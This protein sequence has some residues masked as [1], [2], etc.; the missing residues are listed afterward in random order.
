MRQH[1]KK[2]KL[3]GNGMKVKINVKKF[4]RRQDCIAQI[5]Y[6]YPETI[7]DVRGLIKE[8]V[9]AS[10]A[11]YLDRAAQSGLLHILSA[12]TTEDMGKSGKISFS[13]NYGSKLPQLEDSIRTALEGFEDGLAVIFLDGKRLEDLEETIQLMP[14][15]EL[16]FVRLSPLAG[17]MW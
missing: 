5:E 13:V 14:G 4:S 15:S 11:G 8:T 6:D 3:M 2:E 9:N 7:R 10:V 17:R 1:H 12:E 16:T